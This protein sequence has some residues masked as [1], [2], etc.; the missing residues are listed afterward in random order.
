MNFFIGFVYYGVS[1][2]SQRQ[3]DHQNIFYIPIF[4]QYVLGLS[5]LTSGAYVLAYTTPQT[6]W[7]LATGF[8]V[9]KTNHYKRLI[10]AGGLIWCLGFGLQLTFHPGVSIGQV[11]G[12]LQ[13]NSIGVSCNLQL[14]LIALLATTATQDRAVVTAARNF[15]RTMGGAFGLA[16]SN[17]IYNN[18][19][20]GRLAAI[21][22]LTD[23]QRT[24]LVNS[25]LQALSQLDPAVKD[26][27][28]E[29][30]MGGLKYVYL[31]F[32]LISGINWLISLLI[33]VS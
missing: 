15:L 23:Q 3:A 33:K 5:A 13:L 19:V 16:V 22:D 2:S 6:V 29:A 24:D 9:S 11:M 18:V 31:C 25:A 26:E 1:S 12:I 32:T 21:S 8:Y 14:P 30:Y 10:I 17:S 4:L 28:V 27:V 20:V 7:G